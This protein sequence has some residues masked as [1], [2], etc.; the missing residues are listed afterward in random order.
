MAARDPALEIA[1]PFLME[2][3]NPDPLK[4]WLEDPFSAEVIDSDTSRGYT[5]HI[6]KYIIKN[7]GF[8]TLLEVRF[9]VNEINGFF[10]ARITAMR[11]EI[12]CN[13]VL[14]GKEGSISIEFTDWET[15][16]EIT[17]DTFKFVPPPGSHPL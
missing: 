4:I 16:P 8:S 5:Q 12:G 3:L 13:Q 6:A 9:A 10:P 7:F 15:N 2:F 14:H 11:P 1:L 17:D